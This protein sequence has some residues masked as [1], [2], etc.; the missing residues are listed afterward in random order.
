MIKVSTKVEKN[1]K[2][3]DDKEKLDSEILDNAP[4]NRRLSPLSN[5]C[6]HLLA[7]GNVVLVNTRAKNENKTNDNETFEHDDIALENKRR[8]VLAMT[9]QQEESHSDFVKW[10]SL[11]QS[12][13][14]DTLEDAKD[15]QVVHLKTIQIR[16]KNKNEHLKYDK[17]N[18]NTI[19]TNSKHQRRNTPGKFWNIK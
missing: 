4:E 10:D 16:R 1:V 14:G 15:M 12:N 2:V 3:V 5:I 6:F 18:L 13:F 7:L 11:M 17:R 8:E 19:E 9:L